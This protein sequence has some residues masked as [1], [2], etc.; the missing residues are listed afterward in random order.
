MTS[1]MTIRTKL[2]RRAVIKEERI[3]WVYLQ[4][5]RQ[6]PKR[7]LTRATAKTLSEMQTVT[8][9]HVSQGLGIKLRLGV[10]SSETT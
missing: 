6:S 3:G 10:P 5:R 9:G 2:S 7:D 8:N 1:R 4:Q